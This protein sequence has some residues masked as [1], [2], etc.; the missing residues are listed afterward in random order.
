VPDWLY[1][2][3]VDEALNHW[4]A[5]EILTYEAA[6][7]RYLTRNS[8]NRDDVSDLRQEVYVR[9]YEA[10]KRDRPAAPKAFLFSTARHLLI[11]RAR[12]GRVVSIEA[13]G[14]LHDLNVLVDEMSPERRL[15]GRQE[16]K[17]LSNA[18]GLL[19]SKCREVV[20]LRK[21]DEMSQNEV[22]QRLGISVRTVEC[23]VQKGMRIL[24][25]ALF[26]ELAQ[27][28]GVT[29]DTTESESRDGIQ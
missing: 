20:W 25:R 22:A 9:V 16:L 10:A 26:G 1:R 28:N 27:R 15:D 11:D 6:L 2:D 23:Q 24:A 29:D 18:F 5:R 7:E 14:D 21:V 17:Q 3:S 12:R 19:P 13:A 8:R 4:F